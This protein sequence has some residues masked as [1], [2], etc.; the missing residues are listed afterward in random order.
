MSGPYEKKM[1]VLTDLS[2]SSHPVTKDSPTLP[3]SSATDMGYYNGHLS[4]GQH[5]FFQTQAYS[6]TISS[7][8]YPH[9]PHPQYNFNGLVGNESFL[10]KDDY[11]YGYRPFVHYREPPVQE[12]VSVK[13]EPETEVRMVNGKPK[14]IRK[15]RT[16]YSS[17]QLAALQR[18]FQKAQYLALPERAELAAQLGLT[19][20]QVKIWFQNRR[21]KFK[22]LYKNGEGPDMEH[23]PNNS[24]SMA[25]NS[26]SSP[27][28]WDNSGS[29]TPLQQQQQQQSLPQCSSP[30]YL[31]NYHSWYT[32]QNQSGQHLQPSEVMHQPPPDTVY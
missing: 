15:P 4:T 16:I 6:P 13:E 12:T 21:S 8:G 29:R 31:E 3:E 5:D 23:S 28:I 19:Q 9:P 22:K 17:Y 24:D 27:P 26:P 10:P 1:A 25:C 18:R 7:Y 20:T 30:S 2:T 32:Q 11:Q 14:K